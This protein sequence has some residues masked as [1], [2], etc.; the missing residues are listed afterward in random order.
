MLKQRIF[1]QR[2]GGLAFYIGTVN[3]SAQ[4]KILR[5][6]FSG[7][8]AR[9]AGGGLYI[10]L[11]GANSSHSISIQ[12]CNFTNNSAKI[13]A[14][15]DTFY[16]PVT[17]TS[18]NSTNGLLAHRV[19]IINCVFAGNTA[20]YGGALSNIQLGYLNA[21]YVSNCSFVDNE[22]PLGAALYLHFLFTTFSFVPERRIVIKDW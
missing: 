16:H 1:T 2:G 20:Q 3:N 5:C 4:V 13:G 17:Y 9:G 15:L 18:P 21:L 12:E 10:N 11:L 14:G 22:G 6:S 19:A 8:F 7:N